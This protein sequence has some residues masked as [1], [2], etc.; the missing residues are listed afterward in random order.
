MLH[1]QS[2]ALVCMCVHACIRVCMHVRA[3]AHVCV[4]GRVGAVTNDSSL[5]TPP[6]EKRSGLPFYLLLVMQVASGDQFTRFRTELR[7]IKWQ[8]FTAQ[9]RS[10]KFCP[11][12]M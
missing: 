7:E 11:K 4:A 2:G 10:C 9:P 1:W 12:G 8:F 3:C 6:L 5:L